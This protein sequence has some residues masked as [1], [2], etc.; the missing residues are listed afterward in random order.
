VIALIDCH[1]NANI[2]GGDGS[3][4]DIVLLCLLN[5]YCIMIADQAL[6]FVCPYHAVQKSLMAFSTTGM[7]ASSLRYTVSALIIPRP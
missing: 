7:L 2:D 1:V 5:Q 6:C 3:H 4:P